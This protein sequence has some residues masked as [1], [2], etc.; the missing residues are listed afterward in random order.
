MPV[1]VAPDVSQAKPGAEVLDEEQ[2]CRG[3]AGVKG[4]VEASV[5]VQQAGG[6]TPFSLATDDEHR[7]H[8]AVLARV[9]DLSVK[10]KKQKDARK[11]EKEET[12]A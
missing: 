2:P 10:T 11:N 1:Y 9:T 4:D 6:G 8:R 3:K 12:A 5:A 7:H